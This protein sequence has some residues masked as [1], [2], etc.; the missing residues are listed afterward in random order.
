MAQ[1]LVLKRR[2]V[3]IPAP[4]SAF[5]AEARARFHDRRDRCMLAVSNAQKSQKRKRPQ[6]GPFHRNPIAVFR[7]ALA[8]LETRIALAD[9]EYLAATTHDLAV[10]MAL[11]CGLEGRQHFHGT[12]RN[13]FWT[14]KARNCKGF[15]RA[16]KVV[17][18]KLRVVVIHVCGTADSTA[19]CNTFEG[20]VE[21][22]L[23]CA[24]A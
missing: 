1:F 8:R 13:S 19:K 16:W 18:G 7:S 14:W 22:P 4:A 10:A 23:G 24:E 21:H 12:P 3:D 5:V 9:H 6:S 17:G 11:L 2:T 15:L 20:G